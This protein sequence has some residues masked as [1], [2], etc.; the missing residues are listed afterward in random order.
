MEKKPIPHVTSPVSKK[1][2]KKLR[3]E[4]EQ[5]R[6]KLQTQAGAIINFKEELPPEV[7]NVFLS[8]VLAFE[9]A[10]QNMKMVSV[11][12]F[13]GRP[14]Y[15][16][17]EELTPEEISAELKRLQQLLE[18]GQLI[19]DV[20]D[21]Y[22]DAIIYKF[23][24]E[25]LFLQDT[26]ESLL[27]GMIRHFTYEAFYPN[28]KL[29]IRERVLD[30]LGD[31]FERKLDEYSWELNAQ[32]MLPKGIIMQRHAVVQRIKAIFASYIA[33]SDCKYTL[34]DVSFEWSEEDRKGLG[35]AEGNVSFLAVP[36]HGEPVKMEGPYKLYLS[37]EG[38]WWSIYYFVFPGFTWYDEQH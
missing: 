28:H 34:C 24:T 17:I 12:E 3:L 15:K 16:K 30:F 20:L 1:K 31:W 10:S 18:D 35:F 19:L 14:E 13:L 32:F 23:I 36:E 27:P 37:N 25:E 33:F 22:D 7:E 8:S 4:N 21:E 29:D 26:Y 38:A 9:E 5:M 6:H 2:R 11:Y